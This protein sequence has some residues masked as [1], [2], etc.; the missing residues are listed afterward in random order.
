M[1]A[2]KVI[3]ELEFTL[4]DVCF[5]GLKNVQ[6][7]LLEKLTELQRW[8][9]ELGMAEGSKQTSLLIETLRAC[10]MAETSVSAA[11]GQLCALEFYS[12]NILGRINRQEE[13]EPE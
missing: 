10:R 9:E 12:K 1:T 7:A 5:S 8:M 2:E 11:A 13:E 3:Q 6:P 4:S